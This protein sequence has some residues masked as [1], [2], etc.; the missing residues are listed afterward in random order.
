MDP[1]F[2]IKI[3]EP[4][5]YTIWNNDYGCRNPSLGLVTKARAY[6]VA[7]QEGVQES[8]RE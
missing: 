4:W 8:V 1:Y 6:K 5:K 7:G 2:V 3:Q